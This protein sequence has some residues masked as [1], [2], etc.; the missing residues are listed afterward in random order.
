MPYKVLIVDDDSIV[1]IGLK[2]VVDWKR[3]ELEIIGEASDGVEAYELISRLHPDIVLTD[4]HMPRSDGVRLMEQ[5]KK[6]FP[7][8]LF[9]VLSCYNDLEYVKESM[10]LGAF[11]YLLKDEIVNTDKLTKVLQNAINALEASHSRKLASF[12]PSQ[13]SL[14]SSVLRKRFLAD[15]LEG[16]VN[17]PHMINA[18]TEE[19]HLSFDE[20]PPFF[21]VLELDD[22]V[23]VLRRFVDTDSLNYSVKRLYREILREYGHTEF[24]VAAP[25]V[26]C[27][28]VEIS[29]RSNIITPSQRILSILERVRMLFHREFHSSCTIY[30]DQI[31]SF[32][33]LT[34]SYQRINHVMC[35]EMGKGD[36]DQIFCMWERSIQAN[37]EDLKEQEP[38]HNAQQDPVESICA[39]INA[40]YSENISLDGL[41]QYTNYSKYYICKLFRKKVGVNITDYI[42]DVRIAQAKK[43][44]LAGNIKIG[45]IAEKVGFNNPSYFHKIFKKTVGVTPKEYLRMNQKF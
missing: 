21:V 8:T 5:A 39:Y 2:S 25:N 28:L 11:D 16:K 38:L 3:L 1:R 27:A 29:A 15:L 20:N 23:G 9:L 13:A 32:S 45:E 34:Q 6:D 37:P 44:L 19:L 17:D 7:E 33:E 36:R 12:F 43:M 40:H 30:A 26:F 31:H 41:A 42:A 24:F 14:P 10:K 22:Y 18:A 4:M 35:F